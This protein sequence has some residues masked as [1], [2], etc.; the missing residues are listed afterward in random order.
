MLDI[1]DDFITMQQNGFVKIY[2]LDS[3][4]DDKTVPKAGQ[5]LLKINGKEVGLKKLKEKQKWGD[6]SKAQV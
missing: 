1:V 5:C 2:S 3:N 4:I 6:K